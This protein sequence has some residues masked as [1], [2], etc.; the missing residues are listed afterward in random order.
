[1]I[2]KGAVRTKYECDSSTRYF[3]PDYAILSRVVFIGN[4]TGNLHPFPHKPT[5]AHM[6]MGLHGNGSRV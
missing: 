3:I 1:M 2:N 5:S 6:G 4:A